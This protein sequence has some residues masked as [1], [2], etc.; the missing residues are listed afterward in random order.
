[1]NDFSGGVNFDNASYPFALTPNE[2]TDIFNFKYYRSGDRV[3]LKSRDGLTKT[4]TTAAYPGAIYDIFPFSASDGTEYIMVV[5]DSDLNYKNG[6]TYTKVGDLSSIRGRMCQFNDKLIIADTGALKYWNGGTFD[7]LLDLDANIYNTIGSTGA[8]G[9]AAF[10]VGYGAGAQVR[11][12][13]YFTTPDWGTETKTLT[14]FVVRLKKT[15]SPT[16]NVTAKLYAADGTTTIETS[17]TTLDITTLTTSY[18]TQTFVFT[19]TVS[20]ETD[21]Y[22]TIL[23]SSGDVSNYLQ[24]ENNPVVGA[25][26][27][28]KSYISSWASHL[29]YD[30]I[31]TINIE[32][33]APSASLVI[34]KQDRIYCN[35]V[36]NKNW[37]HY[38]N[39]NDPNDWTTTN[40][41]GYII[42]DGHYKINA[43]HTY[44]KSIY[45]F[46]DQPPAIYQLNGDSPDEYEVDLIYKG[47]TATSQDVVQDVGSD[48]IF[49]Y[50]NSVISL[51][52]LAS[53]GDV[54]KS[55]ISSGIHNTYLRPYSTVHCISGRCETDNQYWICV[56]DPGV[57]ST[58]FVLIYDVEV[59]KWTFF[60]FRNV[61]VPAYSAT[62]SAFGLING[63]TY[64]GASNGHLYYLDYTSKQDNSIDFN[65]YAYT[66]WN[67]LGTTLVKS[68]RFADS[69]LI[70]ATGETYDLEIYTDLN[71]VTPKKTLSMTSLS[72]NG[73][74]HSPYC[75][76]LNELNMNFN[77]VMFKLTNISSGTGPHFLDRI[78][79]DGN[80]LSRYV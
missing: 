76:N 28:V 36:V 26:G 65:L 2:L 77:Q 25:T 35:D 4:S 46:C 37:L 8:T 61:G 58:W 80:I 40:G 68:A 31:A 15:G 64:V 48:L 12:A 53:T 79:L 32:A 14:S 59:G 45:V 69:L 16:G 44:N 20:S 71:T 73:A 10:S 19:S 49:R 72:Q 17:S 70:S 60:D 66:S 39:A 18:S 62:V 7:N 22:F 3:M 27:F 42:F 1:L 57:Q 30:L 47:I 21:Y 41:G 13:Q 11:V 54:E 78:L 43:L 51:R 9:T 23:Y 74:F 5:A 6:G 34:Q 38:C 55:T 29:G 24:V 67:D 63:I 52:S 50:T 33:E 75:S 56:G